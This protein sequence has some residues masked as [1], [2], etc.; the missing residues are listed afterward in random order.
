VLD[1]LAHEEREVLPLLEHN[2]T[3]A[4]W[5]AFLHKERARRTPRER[6]EFL[7]WILDDASQ[8]DTPAVLT[9][10]P[11]PARL[12]YRWVLG[13]RYRAQHRWQIPSSPADRT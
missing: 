13:P 9:E 10:M 8:Q 12:V 4:Q 6:P 11:P 7:T 2:L 5:R 1:H 3:R